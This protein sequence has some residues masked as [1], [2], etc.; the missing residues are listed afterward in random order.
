MKSSDE[1]YIYDLSNLC[2]DLLEKDAQL[3]SKELVLESIYARLPAD[4]RLKSC[5][6]QAFRAAVPDILP[7]V[8][9]FQSK[10][11]FLISV[12]FD[13][14]QLIQFPIKRKARRLTS[15]LK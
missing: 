6:E 7:I 12:N 9:N 13:I 2:W 10:L 4:Y 14:L 8:M 1:V 3:S 5:Y 15:N 11:Y